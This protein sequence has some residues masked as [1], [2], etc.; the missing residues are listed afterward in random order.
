MYKYKDYIDFFQQHSKGS[1]PLQKTKL[2]DLEKKFP[3]VIVYNYAYRHNEKCLSKTIFGY[4]FL[5]CSSHIFFFTFY[6]LIE[7]SAY[8]RRENTEKS[9]A[10]HHI[11]LPYVI[12]NVE[13]I[14]AGV[15]IHK[16]LCILS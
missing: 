11:F 7:I 1:T 3:K 15:Y 5:S 14:W 6:F 12:F 13:I 2:T 4:I 16:L 10:M 9:K 8:N